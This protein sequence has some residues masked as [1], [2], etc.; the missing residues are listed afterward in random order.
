MR[1]YFHRIWVQLSTTCSTATEVDPLRA[2]VAVEYSQK[3]TMASE[4]VDPID[5]PLHPTLH[6]AVPPELHVLHG[7]NAGPQIK[8]LA[9]ATGTRTRDHR[10]ARPTHCPC[11]HS[12]Y[13][14]RRLQNLSTCPNII[15][16]A[17]D[18]TICVGIVCYQ[19]HHS[20]H[21]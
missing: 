7:E 9:A 10:N 8:R 2:P 20:N 13:S 15:F 4:T 16:H 11:G 17:W 6:S 12:G 21:E 14:N 19:I 5:W 1:I 3:R 18:H